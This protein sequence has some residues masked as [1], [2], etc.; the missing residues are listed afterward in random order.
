[1]KKTRNKTTVM[2]KNDIKPEWHFIDAEDKVLGRISTNIA[3]LLIGKHK[4][5]FSNT[6][7]TGDKVVVTNAS[8]IRVTGR[9]LKHKKYIRHSGYPKGLKEE[10]L[11][12]LLK[13]RPTEVV[14]K[15]VK[16]MLP[17]N[18]LLKERM[19]NLYIYKGKEH[20]H[21]AQKG[22]K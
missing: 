6:L 18:K 13:R 12:S 2:T 21:I 15:A 20:P 3:S 16:R 7:N 1:M 17:Q 9:K 10:S 14:R 11:E 4:S 8:K 5:T 19:K 22:E